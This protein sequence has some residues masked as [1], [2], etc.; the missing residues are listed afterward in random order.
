M[1]EKIL[2]YKI[3]PTTCLALMRAAAKA[4]LWLGWSCSAIAGWSWDMLHDSVQTLSTPQCS[5]KLP[6]LAL[7]RLLWTLSARTRILLGRYWSNLSRKHS[8][9][10]LLAASCSRLAQLQLQHRAEMNWLAVGQL[11]TKDRRKMIYLRFWKYWLWSNLEVDSLCLFGRV[12]NNFFNL[13]EQTKPDNKTNK[14]INAFVSLH[15]YDFRDGI[16]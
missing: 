9:G 12:H 14:C 3:R 15:H 4:E 1:L 6:V 5:A 16:H 8:A 10:L 2:N 11:A 7:S 13:I